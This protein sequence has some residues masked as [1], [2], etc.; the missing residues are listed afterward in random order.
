MQRAYGYRLLCLTLIFCRIYPKW[1]ILYLLR[2]TADFTGQLY[3]YALHSKTSA[4][5]VV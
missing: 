5:D 3:A 4:V 1:Y 2:Y